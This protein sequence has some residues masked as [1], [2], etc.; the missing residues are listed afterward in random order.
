[1]VT[2]AVAIMPEGRLQAAQVKASDNSYRLPKTAEPISY[3]VYLKPDFG[4][5]TFEGDVKVRVQIHE[6]TDAIVLH[7]NR[8]SIKAVTVVDNN[9]D[10]V[11]I[12]VA[13]I[14]SAKH[15]LTISSIPNFIKG[16]EYSINIA[17]TGILSEDMNGF[18]RSSYTIGNEIR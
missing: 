13:S 16:T 10:A 9:G 5:F 11:G 17:F 18:Y 8:Q 14:D 15:F 6:D 3:E 7:S 1:M 12:I 2:T 4:S